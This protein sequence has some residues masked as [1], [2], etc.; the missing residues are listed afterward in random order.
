MTDRRCVL[1]T[2]MHRSGTSLVAQAVQAMGV[3]L[4]KTLLKAN[5]HNQRGYYED[6][7]VVRIHDMLLGALGRPWGASVH[8]LPMPDGWQNSEPAVKAQARIRAYLQQRTGDVFAVKDP[9]ISLLFPLWQA[10]ADQSGISPVL[11]ICVR[12]AP[13]VAASLLRRD[14]LDHS[15]GMRLWL[16]YTACAIADAPAGRSHL[17]FS[18][19]WHDD[20][21]RNPQRL[22]NILGVS[23]PMPDVFE[24]ALQTH[25]D[26]PSEDLF[27]RWH[28]ALEKARQGD[29]TPG[30]ALK[31]LA[32]QWQ[33]TARIFGAGPRS[34]RGRL[35]RDF[36]GYRRAYAEL[37][38]RLAT[39]QRVAPAPHPA[40]DELDAL[41]QTLRETIEV[42]N[43]IEDELSALGQSHAELQIERDTLMARAIANLEAYQTIDACN[44]AANEEIERQSQRLAQLHKT[45]ASQEATHM[46]QMSRVNKVLEQI[47][48]QHATAEKTWTEEQ[49]GYETTIQVLGADLASL[50]IENEGLHRQLR[51]HEAAA[52]ALKIRAALLETTN[53]RLMRWHL[54]S[55]LSRAL[56][57]RKP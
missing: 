52:R 30:R 37:E 19:D 27:L 16:Q 31:A 55:L 50:R 7:E 20:P 39:M 38:R 17:L 26:P 45:L 13:E 8:G 24:P 40:Q 11:V 53:T 33:E 41:R 54:P 32:R 9:R 1:I 36:S 12:P 15:L 14:G 3:P 35:V 6:A 25:Q 18:Q 56:N 28:S 2:G 22:A 49:A 5:A 46:A 43:T 47:R 29:G 44:T 48:A 23:G 57:R 21:D 42:S 10:A 34:A 51:D 4:G